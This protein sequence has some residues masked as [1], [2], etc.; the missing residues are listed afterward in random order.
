M[1]SV[2]LVCDLKCVLP[3]WKFALHL[4]VTLDVADFSLLLLTRWDLTCH[5]FLLGLLR[6][7][8]VLRIR[9]DGAKCCDMSKRVELKPRVRIVLISPPD[10][11]VQKKKMIVSRRPG[12]IPGTKLRRTS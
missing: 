5:R 9:L 10:M 6:G 11:T 3:G 1:V 8:I 4:R 12:E 2:R 7:C